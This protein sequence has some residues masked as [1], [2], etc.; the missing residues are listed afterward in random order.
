MKTCLGLLAFRSF[1]LFLLIGCLG[2][3]TLTTESVQAQDMGVRG[4]DFGDAALSDG[5]E[6]QPQ[7]APIAV[8]ISV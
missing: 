5:V 6:F 7:S 1:L 3:P 4:G 2:L 8:F